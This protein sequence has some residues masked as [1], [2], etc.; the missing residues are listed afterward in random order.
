MVI[1]NLVHCDP[2]RCSLILPVPSP[3]LHQIKALWAPT[4]LLHGSGRTEVSQALSHRRRYN[5][6]KGIS[7]NGRNC[8]LL[9]VV[10]KNKLAE[11]NFPDVILALISVVLY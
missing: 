9:K 8:M 10:P 7:Q 11:K 3:L 1:F 6:K 5:G 2:L 4:L